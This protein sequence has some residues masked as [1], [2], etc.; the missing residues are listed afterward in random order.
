MKNKIISLMTASVISVS[1]IPFGTIS[2][3]EGNNVSSPRQMERLDR[4]TVAVKTSGGVYLS[5]RLLGT[6][7][8]SNQAFDI[9]RD[10]EKIDTTGTHDATCYT[11]PNGSETSQYIV[12]P[13]G[14]SIIGEKS[15]TP[16]TTNVEYK[17]NS[18]AYKDILFTAPEGGTTP[19]GDSYTYSANDMSVGDL[20]GDGEYEII[21]K[22]DPSNSHDNSDTG[23]TGEVYMDAY[24]LD[25]TRLWR[26]DLGKNIR[27]GAHYT[28]FIVYDFDSDGKSEIAF[29]TA[30][31]S[32]DGQNNYVSA[33]GKST[34]ITE[35]DNNADYRSSAGTVL[36]GPEWL[37]IFDGETGSAMDTVNYD[38]PRSINSDNEWGDGYGNRCERYL[39]G[40]AYLD[41]VHPSLI[42]TRGYYTY[43][44]AAAYSW[45]GENLT[46]QWLSKNEPVG[47]SASSG[48]TV[49]YADGTTKN[50]KT[51]TLYGQGAHSL[52]VADVDN[53]GFDE[54]IFGSAILDHDGTVLLYDGRGHGDAE[55]VS[56]F[57]ND[58]QQEI[59]MV[60]EAGKGS[61]E[62]IPFAVDI[63]RPDGDVML[64]EAVGD[65]GRGVMANIDD[66]YAASSGNLAAFWSV[67]DGDHVYSQS[68]DSIAS[69]TKSNTVGFVNFLIYWDGDLGRELLDGTAIGKKSI[70]P[71]SISRIYYNSK[72]SMFPDVSSNND[73]KSTPGL[74]ADILGDWR[75]EVIYP[76]SDGTGMRI[77]FS[78]IP[79]TYRL[80]TLMHD[81]QYRCA[82]AWQN[83]GYNQPPHPSYYIGSAALAKDGNTTLNY[84]DPATAFTEVTYPNETEKTPPP[85]DIPTSKPN[86]KEVTPQADTYI[87]YNDTTTAHGADAELRINQ[88]QNM[89]TNTTP[90]LKNASGLGLIRFDLSQYADEEIQS[91][92][93]KLFSKYTNTDGA[94][95]SLHLDYCSKDDWNEETLTAD[96]IT[97]RGTGTPLSS[98]GLEQTPKYSTEYAEISF[99]VTDAVRADN[100]N[101]HTFTLW[102]FTAREQIIASKEYTGEDAK[103]PTLV[104]TFE[105]SEFTG[106]RITPP[107]KTVYTE[108]E[109]LDLTG[110]TVKAVYDDG[111]TI[112]MPNGYEV[113][114][115]D[116]TKTGNQTVTISFRDKT[117]T[118][119]VTVNP[120]E[121][122][123]TGIQL[124]PPSKTTYVEGEELDTAGMVVKAEYNNG[125]SEEVTG[126]TVTGY[127][128]NTIGKQTITVTYEEK[129]A[130]F[131][132]TVTERIITDVYINKISDTTSVIDGTL[133]G[134]VTAKLENY[135]DTAVL[136]LA[137]HDGNGILK[138]IQI[139]EFNGAEVTFD[140]LN[141]P[142]ISDY[143]YSIFAWE[144]MTVFEPIC[145]S[146]SKQ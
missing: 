32:K 91:A 10:G 9:Y 82:V 110:M 100:D 102:T 3:A 11:D 113:T 144:N 59:F 101:V 90:G 131:D 125:T 20:D 4:G 126:Y 67:A 135:S 33:A 87:V 57:D 21:V 119:D 51:K 85:V 13:Q 115:Y 49:V 5:W 129:T 108:G 76:L 29:K 112:D 37:T 84:L 70:E 117:A 105:P 39:A 54:I 41:G 42:M 88:A 40:V 66:E 107:E 78:T 47:N 50:D 77:Y 71:D 46:E 62:T 99:D 96:G 61:D 68:G 93:L 72:N 141:I 120:K 142:E 137:V 143:T 127:D 36:T 124:T 38:P 18:V 89:Y 79:T 6:E 65:I 25:G 134:T 98:L 7:D 103:V 74:V 19:A 30:P 123:L 52:S 95:S 73:T 94:T 132:V 138:D 24:K 17:T 34:D 16:W 146:A 122:I 60:H 114:G 128:K 130:T 92:E 15:V 1:A 116:N 140:S 69:G 106:I 31:G 145:E 75:E 48:C 12:V 97:I 53:D 81:S 118:F 83:V 56:D 45:D 43:A 2:F 58:G 133:T 14:E 22:W 139:K 28:Q 109:D 64:Q 111:S 86:V 27:A 44:Y 35:A 26:M 63:K 55:H 136:I 121:I 8:L 23:Y 104:L 80:T